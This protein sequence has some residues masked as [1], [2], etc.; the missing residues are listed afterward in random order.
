MIRTV[1]RDEYERLLAQS[2]VIEQ[3]GYGVKV[4]Q[5]P[6]GN[7]LKTFW[8]RRPVSSRRIYPESLRFTLHAGSLKR[9]GIATV[10]MIERIRI[11]HLKRTG[12]IYRPLAGRTLRQVAAAGKFDGSM[13]G[14]L[15]GFIAELHRKGVHFHSLH[16]GNV[17]LCPGGGFGLIDISNMKIFPWPLG[18]RTRMRNFGHIF[19]YQ[20]DLGIL[21][22][23]GIK[24][25]MAGYL[26]EKSAQHLKQSLDVILKRYAI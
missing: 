14:R 11:P 21:T 23:V 2:A 18:T 10:E 1:T 17:L 6:D 26:Q 4:L 19:R 25:F 5:Q 24:E 20:E 12:V 8:Y 9:R 13:A 7:F 15:G 16:L 22:G 3:D